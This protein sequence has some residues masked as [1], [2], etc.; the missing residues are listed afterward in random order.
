[1]ASVLVLSLA[2]SASSFP[3]TAQSYRQQADESVRSKSWD[4]AVAAYRKALELA[5]ND[6]LTHYDLGVALGN[7]GAARQALEEFETAVRL[8][9][10]WAPAH[11][12]LGTTYYELHELPSALKQLRKVIQLDPSNAN[13]HQLLAHV[14]VDQSD[15]SSALAELT[16]AVALKPSGE[17]YFELGQVEGQLGKLDAAAVQ[18]RK[19]L[20]LDPK[21]ARAHVMLG[22]V[23]R[24]QSNHK[25]ALAEFR[26]AVRLDPNDPNAQ[27]NLGKELKAD[28]DNAGAIRAFQKAIELKPDFEQAHYN[29][30]IALRSQGDPEAAHKE[31][32]ELSDLREFR[33]RLAQAKLLILRGVDALKQGQL[34]Q[35]RDLFQ[36]AINEA[37]NFPPAITIWASPGNGNKTSPKRSR[38]IRRRSS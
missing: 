20:R 11:Y 28:G 13:A 22:I 30:G 17:L 19:A 3:Q 32:N 8:K 24:R 10:A 21:L 29:L 36:Q 31:L 37:P 12:A 27:F 14:Y 5:P 1:M 25:D 15:F 16:R 33:A 35:A 18:Y 4:E 26:Q 38:P 2:V 6:A 9:P 34:D 23:L 7:K